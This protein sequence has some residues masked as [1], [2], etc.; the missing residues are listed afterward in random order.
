MDSSQTSITSENTE[1]IQINLSSLPENVLSPPT[2]DDE[3]TETHRTY[4][5]NDQAVLLPKLLE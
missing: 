5:I 4:Y 2:S 3:E 1:D